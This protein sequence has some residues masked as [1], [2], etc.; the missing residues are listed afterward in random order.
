MKKIRYGIVG[1]GGFGKKRRDTLRRSGCFE[2]TGGVDI[3]PKAFPEAERQEK[4]PIPIY[5]NVEEMSN[6]KEIEAVFI[7]TPASLHVEQAM[8]AARAGKPIFVEKPLGY[9]LT[10][11]RELVSYCEKNNIPHGHGFSQRFSDIYVY[12]KEKI[13]SGDLG[14]VVSVSCASMHSGGLSFDYGNWRFTPKVNPGGPLYHLGVHPMD[15]LSFLFGCG[16]WL[17]G[18][19]ENNITNSSIED[20]YVLIGV[21]GQIPCTLHCHYVCSYRHAMEIYGTKGNLFISHFPDKLE[22]QQIDASSSRE[23]TTNLTDDIPKYNME[24]EYLKDFALSIQ[25]KRQ[26]RVNGQT[27]LKS[28]ELLFN[29]LEV[30]VSND[31]IIDKVGCHY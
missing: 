25:E 29:A 9:D 24:T 8:I 19:K 12:V 27:A 21:F 18:I 11:C 2:I 4:K 6:A 10:A 31:T 28:I 30:S 1:I 7:S 16:K 23:I 14:H 3:D 17:Y 5:K 15:T 13:Q 26:P 22:F 20:G